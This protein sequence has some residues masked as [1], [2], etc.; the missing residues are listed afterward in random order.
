MIQT[1]G[2]GGAF[3]STSQVPDKLRALDPPVVEA[4]FP[5][6]GLGADYWSEVL[7]PPFFQ[8]CKYGAAKEQIAPAAV[9]LEWSIPSPPDYHHFNELPRMT[10][11]ASGE[12]AVKAAH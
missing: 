9:S 5:G 8:K 6:H 3:P 1:W 10:A 7:S 11:L 2:L 4:D 12:T